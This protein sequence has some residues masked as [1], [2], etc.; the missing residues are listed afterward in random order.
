MSNFSKR[1]TRF[2]AAAYL[3][4]SIRN[5]TTKRLLEL[6]KPMGKAIEELIT[7]VKPA[8]FYRWCRD[9][10][11]NKKAKNPKGGQRKPREIREIVMTIAKYY[12]LRLH[13]NFR[14]IRKLGIKKLSRQTVRNILKEEGIEPSPD[15][16]SD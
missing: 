14:R 6:G 10:V 7:I 13:S 3:A 1:K 2:F 4:K 12:R 9:G 5:P 15:R 8:T 16:T 11:T